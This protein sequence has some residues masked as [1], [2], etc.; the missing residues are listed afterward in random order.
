MTDDPQ[1]PR[2]V[3][4][5]KPDE[6]QD[7]TGCLAVGA[8]L[9]I[10]AGIMIG[11]YALPPILKG[12]YGEKEVAA[13]LRYEG[14]ARTFQVVSTEV[15]PDEDGGPSRVIVLMDVRSNRSWDATLADWTLEVEHLEDW[16]RAVSAT[17]NGEPGFIV[18]LAKDVHL[19]LIFEVEPPIEGD[20][21]LEAIHLANPRLRFELE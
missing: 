3:V 21:V 13:G 7:R 10:V 12:I 20:M 6:K 17:S 4:L 9:G 19:E 2:R 15:I 5:E 8:I 11:M 14:D 18:P 1:Q 16:Q